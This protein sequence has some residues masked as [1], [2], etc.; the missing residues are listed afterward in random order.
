MTIKQLVLSAAIASAGLAATGASAATELLTNGGFEDGD[1]T[2]WTVYSHPVSSVVSS[3]G[4]YHAED[5]TDFARLVG[6][7]CVK[8]KTPIANGFLTQSVTDPYLD[9]ITLTFWENVRKTGK[10]ATALMVV[11]WGASDIP[12]TKVLPT[13]VGDPTASGW[14]EYTA[15][16][17]PTGG[18]D[19]LSFQWQTKPAHFY[20]LDNVQ[21]LADAPEPATWALMLVGFA[22]LGAMARSRRRVAQAAI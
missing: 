17:T 12:L 13:K 10:S 5:G 14:Q 8:C 7:G 4:G 22:G 3:A 6:A 2:G 1:F 9:P 18:S 19:T 20:G 21:L 15:T 11:K 16:L